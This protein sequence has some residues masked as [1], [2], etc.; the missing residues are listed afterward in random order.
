MN[1]KQ[2]WEQVYSTKPFESIS[3]F[4]EHADLSL[5]LIHSTGLGKD[6]AIIDV[7]GETSKLVDDLLGGGYTDSTLLDLS[8]AAIAVAKL[9]Q[10]EHADDVHWMEGDICCAEFTGHRFD[11]WHDRAV[12]LF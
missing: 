4:Q 11:M 2:H 6:A 3:W 1:R 5:R 12:F 9:R 7:G 10:A 8:S